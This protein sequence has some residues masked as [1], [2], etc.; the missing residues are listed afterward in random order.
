MEKG[1]KCT[2]QIH[3]RERLLCHGPHSTEMCHEEVDREGGIVKLKGSNSAAADFRSGKAATQQR[4]VVSSLMH[5]FTRPSVMISSYTATSPNT[6]TLDPTRHFGGTCA[7]LIV[8]DKLLLYHLHG[9]NLVV[10]LQPHQE[11]LGIAST[12]D[13]S[14]EVEILQPQPLR[15]LDPIHPI[16]D[17]LKVLG[18]GPEK[19]ESTI[20]QNP[21][22]LAPNPHP[23]QRTKIKRAKT[24]GF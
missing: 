13:D 14:D 21:K 15:D 20:C 11:D 2:R 3:A 17:R 9:V 22:P 10:F 1:R 19:G 7:Y 23:T 12:P 24:V 8:M 6:D 16:D 18:Q 5:N 4:G